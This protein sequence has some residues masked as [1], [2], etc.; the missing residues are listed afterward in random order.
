MAAISNRQLEVPVHRHFS[1]CR[2]A[3]AQTI[4]KTRNAAKHVFEFC[5]RPFAVTLAV[6]ST[7][8]YYGTG[9][10]M[11]RI[12]ALNVLSTAASIS[13][14]IGLQILRIKL[15][16]PSES[17]P[18]P[19]PASITIVTSE[20]YQQEVLNS[21]TPVVLDV[22]ATWCPPCKIVAPIF[23]KLSQELQGIKFCKLDVEQN[24]LANQLQIT[25][26]P[27]FLLFK[28][29]KMI[30]RHTGALDRNAFLLL[31]AKHLI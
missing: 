17:S 12:I 15:L 28:D 21:K 13:A 8:F 6:S 31:F 24:T 3:I 23:E 30:E 7:I 16:T 26:V 18:L 11:P 10:S 4:N 27:T 22:Y 29:G 1:L 14:I 5:S 9:A 2:E 25:T 19:P 20:N